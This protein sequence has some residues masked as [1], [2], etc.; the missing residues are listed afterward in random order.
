MVGSGVL[1]VSIKKYNNYQ[2]I[3]LLVIIY[4]VD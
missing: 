1:L 2:N 3:N 4:R